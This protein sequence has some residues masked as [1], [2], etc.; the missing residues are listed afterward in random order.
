[1]KNDKLGDRMKMY[2]SQTT[3]LKLIPLLPVVVRLDGN[4]F[5]KFTKGL[6]RPY[7]ER[8]SKLMIETTRFLVKEFNPNIGYTQSDE[9]TLVF[10][11]SDPKTQMIFGGRV[12]KI[13]TKLATSASVFFNKCLKEYLPEKSDKSPTFDC[14]V[15]NVP[16]K[17]EAANA[18]LWRELDATKNSITMAAS[19]LYSH[20]FLNKKNSSDK[21]ELLFEKGVNW[22]DYP[23][24]FKR[25]SYIQRKR[26]Y[27]EFTP[28]E[29]KKL[30]SKHKARVNPDL[31]IERWEIRDID[32]PPLT[33]I[34]N[35][36]DVILFGEDPKP[37]PILD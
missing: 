19:E 11:N 16:T 3:S 22:N 14:R 20:N 27:R 5:S 17:E 12:F 34:E 25:G 1:M 36:V 8:L 9:I 37:Y 30:P 29:L 31:K 10:Y 32:L 18:L 15:F 26:V 6:K 21:Q 35:K 28:E 7:D 13:E 24:F 23:T 4:S 33:K 2:E